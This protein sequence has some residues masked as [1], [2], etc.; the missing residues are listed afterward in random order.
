MKGSHE[1]SW[2]IDELSAAVVAA[3][4]EGYDG[5]PNGRVREVPDQ[6]T[7]R[8]YTTLGLLDRASEMRGRTALY[9]RRH[10]LQLVAIKKLQASGRTL[11]EV[12]RALTG[13]TDIALA[14]LAG[15]DPSRSKGMPAPRP[16]ATRDF[17]RQAPARASSCSP[18]L[19]GAKGD[20]EEEAVPRREPAGGSQTFQGVP[21][22]PDVTLLL[23]ASRPLKSE[24]LGGLRAASVP[25]IDFLA[26]L[27]II[28]PR[29]EG[30]SR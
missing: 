6:R 5:P 23:A 24:D 9:G 14:R 29:G 13:Q 2:T 22:A 18:P 20:G 10:L 12:Q 30:D 27:K 17:W 26:R 21:L 8:Y 28:P 4:A 3:L 19:E 16:R 1:P 11:A 15:L 25:L 7:I